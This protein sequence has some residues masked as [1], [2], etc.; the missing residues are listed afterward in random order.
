MNKEFL[1]KLLHT[2]SI[3]GYEDEAVSL[4]INH[5]K[6]NG[7]KTHVDALNNAYAIFGP[8]EAHISIIVEAHI[9][10]IGFQITYIDDN[11]YIY[12][13]KNG[14][15]DESCIPGSVVQVILK[16]G[17][18]LLGVIGKKPI[19]L[20]SKEE[21]NSITK[22][23]C[24]WIDTGLKA[25]IVKSMV[26][27]GDPVGF[28]PNFI[29]LGESRISSKALDDK[30]GIFIL[31][32]CMERLKD[33]PF[34]SKIIFLASSQEEVGLRGAKA[35]SL[36]FKSD[37]AI[38]I[39][40]DFSTDVPDCS[41]KKYGEIQL[42]KGVVISKHLDSSRKLS[43]LAENIAI[44]NNIEYQLS[45]HI[46]ATGGTNASVFQ[47]ANTN[48][49]TLCIGIPCRYMHT[50]VEMVDLKDI[51]SAVSLIIKLIESLCQ[52]EN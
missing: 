47:T 51:D 19:H 12:I 22:L 31:T 41:V 15:I 35:S 18:K 33:V 49:K 11:G 43:S 9:D 25:E 13:R 7:A 1:S 2:T 17:K 38:C 8:D 50:P 10:E 44:K 48:T 29:E 24:L 42:G 32:E 37:Y 14:G 3:S 21:R 26:R 27:I 39:D 52:I 30:V 6:K 4:F 46:V 16:D 28:S 23:D 5:A 40:V 45:A 34:S 20:Q 36:D